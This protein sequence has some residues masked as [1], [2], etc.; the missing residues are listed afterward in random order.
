MT[1]KGD[2][3]ISSCWIV[4][5]GL[6]GLQ[7]QAIGLAQALG[8]P[9][10]LKEVKRPKGLLSF[11]SP[12]HDLTPPW[13]HLLISCGR[14]SVPVSIAIRR[15]SENKTFTVHIQDPLTDLRNFDAVIVPA[16]DNLQGPNVLVTQGAIHHVSADK[17][18]GAAGHFRPLLASLPRPLVSVLIGGK[19]K[20]QGFTHSSA[21]DLAEK[22]RDAATNTGGGL[23]VS[24]SRRT[25]AANEAILRKVLAG[26]P[27]YIWEGTGENPY[28]G[29][30]AL[31]D[32]IVVTSDSI[33]MI[34]EACSTGKPVY[35]YELP[36]AGK[37]HKQFYK[38]LFQNSMARPFWGD[39]EI[40][41]NI[42]LEETRS[43]AQFVQ[44][45]LRKKIIREEQYA[46]I[47]SGITS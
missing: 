6:V 35:I 2:L 1:V 30:L 45:H 15:A 24:F 36:H 27:S 23:A 29:F 43:A 47:N 12:R 16:H 8:I 39:V 9:Y 26:V 34:S 37:R 25:G 22:L 14:Q 42:P 7:N 21:H 32:A 3:L 4:T 11:L 20:H 41:K 19:N 10:V 38:S 44:E 5:E 40:W 17:L 31:A 18:I 28:F 33:S 46:D 13:P